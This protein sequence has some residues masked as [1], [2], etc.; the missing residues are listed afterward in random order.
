MGERYYITDSW[1]DPYR[2]SIESRIAARKAREAVLTGD[3]P[4]TDFANGHHWYGL[5]RIPEGWVFREYAPNA[6]SIYLIGT[7]NN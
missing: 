2:G 5:H 3:R 7:F 1:L 4:L 6:T